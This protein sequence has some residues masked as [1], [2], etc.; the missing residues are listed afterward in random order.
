MKKWLMKI[1]YW[2]IDELDPYWS[3]SNLWKLAIIILV[4]WFGHSLMH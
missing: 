3:W 2:V 4:A 1:A